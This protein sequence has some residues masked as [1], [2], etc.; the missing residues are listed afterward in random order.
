MIVQA[1]PHSERMIDVT[2]GLRC[3][4]RL[5]VHIW[6]NCRIR[7]IAV[8]GFSAASLLAHSGTGTKGP[9]R[10]NRLN[11]SRGSGW[12]TDKAGVKVLRPA[13]NDS[14][15]ITGSLFPQSYNFKQTGLLLHA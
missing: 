11:H 6:R 13:T 4:G 9:L 5:D 3:D 8:L 2:A 10:F 1:L 12:Q 15:R 14:L 7:E